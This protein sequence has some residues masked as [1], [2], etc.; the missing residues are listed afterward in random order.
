MVVVVVIV[1]VAIV[2]GD[3]WGGMRTV[4]GVLCADLK[5]DGYIGW[6][7]QASGPRWFRVSLPYSFFL[8]HHLSIRPLLIE[9]VI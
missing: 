5:V 4:D 1:V 7:R 3:G 6:R 9:T 8:F 2:V